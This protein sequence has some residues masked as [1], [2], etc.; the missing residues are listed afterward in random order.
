MSSK[1]PRVNGRGKPEEDA[2]LTEFVQ[3]RSLDAKRL[4]GRVSEE[5]A[6]ELVRRSFCSEKRAANGKRQFL[7]LLVHENELPRIGSTA[8]LVTVKHV[9]GPRTAR[10]ERG[11]DYYEHRYPESVAIT[12][13]T[14]R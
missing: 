3:V 1:P 9:Q 14:Q 10:S 5:I 8:S 4:L 6:N 13:R 7:R 11:A 12:D 2:R